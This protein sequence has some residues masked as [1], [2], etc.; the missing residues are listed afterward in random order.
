[1]STKQ[2]IVSDAT[3]K[4]WPF[5][6]NFTF[7]CKDGRVTAATCKYYCLLVVNLAITNCCKEPILNVAEFL[8]PSLK[9]L[10]CT[11][12]SPV[13]CENQSF[14]LSRNVANFIESHF[15]F[16][17]YFLQYE[18]FFISFLDGCYHYLVFMDPVNGCSRSKL[19]VKEYIS[20][21]SNIRFG[22]LCLW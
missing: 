22:Y 16:L 18:G 17:C 5:S 2:E 19:L 7:T 13:S 4:T 3:F 1:M 6:S 11:K 14:F 10:P 20:L 21:K 12:T 9:T 15:V 8:D